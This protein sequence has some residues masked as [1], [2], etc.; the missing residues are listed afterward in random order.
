MM[1]AERKHKVQGKSQLNVFINKEDRQR[2][3]KLMEHESV[4]YQ[5]DAISLALKIALETLIE[6]KEIE[7]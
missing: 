2:L 7:K 6:R 4:V 5:G 3:S 1:A